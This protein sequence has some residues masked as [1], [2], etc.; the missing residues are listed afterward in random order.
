VASIERVRSPP[1]TSRASDTASCN[2]AETMR[3]IHKA[4]AIPMPMFSASRM[5]EVMR[6][7]LYSPVAASL[8]SSPPLV[9]K[10]TSL[11]TMPLISPSVLA[12]LPL[13]TA[14]ASTFWLARDSVIILA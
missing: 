5:I 14:R 13:A 9:F 2:G 11:V 12:E 6:A 8:A 7:F 10:S 4:S 3:A 1:A